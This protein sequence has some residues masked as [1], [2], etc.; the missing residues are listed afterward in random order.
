MSNFE[1]IE[2]AC[3]DSFNQF[4][5]ENLKKQSSWNLSPD[6]YDTKIQTDMDSTSYAK[7][8]D[9]FSDTGMLLTSYSNHPDEEDI[10]YDH[11]GL[12]LLA[13]YIFESAIKKSAYNYQDIE[14]I[15]IL[16]NYYNKASTGI[17]HVDKDF[18]EQKYFSV[19][20]HLNTC[21][22]GTIIEENDMIPSVAGNAILFDSNLPHRGVGPS[23]DDSRFVLNILLEYSSKELKS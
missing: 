6:Q 13:Q 10:N 8:I 7:N 5:I 16:W 1:I 4:V 17:F 23:K 2:N 15:R 21:D 22:G 19:I 20:Y 11:E 9:G 18:D 14:L 3:E 12:N